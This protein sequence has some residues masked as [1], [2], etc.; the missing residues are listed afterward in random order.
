MNGN[1]D[2]WRKDDSNDNNNHNTLSIVLDVWQ[3]KRLPV[4]R[5]KIQADGKLTKKTVILRFLYFTLILSPSSLSFFLSTLDGRQEQTSGWALTEFLKGY[6]VK[7]KI[8]TSD[9]C[10]RHTSLIV[11]F[12]Q[13]VKKIH[14][15]RC[16]PID[17][18]FYFIF[19]S[20]SINA[21]SVIH[22]KYL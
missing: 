1:C 8:P 13:R 9:S 21:T 18:L 22:Q 19:A 2:I 12:Q 10:T 15:I 20:P 3:D 5:T 7:R 14:L 16:Q 4:E 6:R 11:S 17:Q